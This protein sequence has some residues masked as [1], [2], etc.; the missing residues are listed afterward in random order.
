[1]Q[2]LFCRVSNGS[3]Y[4]FSSNSY[5]SVVRVSN[6]C[7]FLNCYCVSINCFSLLVTARY[8]TCS[9]NNCKC[10]YNFLHLFKI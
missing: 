10:K 3:S 6:Y 2:K 7:Y 4:F 9:E 5:C 8:E 1:M